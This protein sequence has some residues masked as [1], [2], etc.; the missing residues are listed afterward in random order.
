MDGVNVACLLGDG[1]SRT[2]GF[3]WPRVPGLGLSGGG[4][5]LLDEVDEEASN[6]L[7][8]SLREPGF[9]FGGPSSAMIDN[10]GD[11]L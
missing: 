7:I 1:G 8:L 10:G 2:F 5:G 3:H 4:A 6:C 11:G 9:G